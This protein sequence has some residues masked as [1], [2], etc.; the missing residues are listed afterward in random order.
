MGDIDISSS[1]PDKAIV[2]ETQPS[3]EAAIDMPAEPENAAEEIRT[4][5]DHV[6]TSPES[7]VNGT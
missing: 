5:P 1:H 6:H 7:L 3:D 4:S 2:R